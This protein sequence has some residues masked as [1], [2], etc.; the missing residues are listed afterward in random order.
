MNVT[1]KSVYYQSVTSDSSE[2][3]ESSMFDW[4]I[5]LIINNG[6]VYHLSWECNRPT[7]KDKVFFYSLIKESKRVSMV[8]R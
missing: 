4:K 8:S 5:L 7:V 3:S 6:L 1:A 2:K